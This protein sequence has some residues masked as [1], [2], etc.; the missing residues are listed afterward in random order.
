VQRRQ[1]QRRYAAA[2]H[3]GAFGLGDGLGDARGEASSTY[4]AT[5]KRPVVNEYH[6]VK[7]TDDYQWLENGAD[8]EV[9][10]WTLEQNK[11]TR[12]YFDQAP[13]RAALKEKIKGILSSTS[14]DRYA[15]KMVKDK[16]FAL[17]DQP[18]KQQPFLVVMG[19]PDKAKTEAD[20]KE[21]VLVDPNAIDAKGAT[22]IDWYV[23]S[24]DGKLVAVSMS[25]GGTENG[26]VHVYDVEK[27]AELGDVVPHA[28]SGTAGGSL[29][30][31]GDGKGFYYTRHP[32]AGEVK[33]EDMGFFQQVYFHK[34]GTKDSEDKPLSARTISRGSPRWSCRRART[35]SGSSPACRRATAV[36]T[37]TSSSTRSRASGRASP[38]SRTRSSTRT[39]AP[40]NKLYLLSLKDAPKGK[41]LRVDPAKP[42][43]AKADTLVPHSDVTI[44]GFVVAKSKLYVKDLVGGPSQVRVFDLKGKAAG[45]CPS[46]PSPACGRSCRWTATTCC[47]ATRATRR[48]RPGT[49]TSPK[50]KTPV[51]KTVMAT[52]SSVSFADAEAVR[53]TCTSKDGTKVPDQH[54]PQEGHPA[55]RHEPDVAHRVRRIRHQPPAGRQPGAPRL[56][57]HGRRL[58][59][60]EPARRRRVR[61]GVAPRRQPRQEAERL[62][63]LPRVREVRSWSRS[64]RTRRSS[65]S[66]AARTA[67]C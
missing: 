4:P 5:A 43:L 11:K 48:L 46:R 63:R 19:S 57:R 41:I 50:D 55:R 67:A 13:S 26:T 51:A 32:H 66:W 6:G 15:L 31:A 23:P 62:R 30:W 21:R 56:A 18:P 16:L 61:R 64:T 36:N 8:P 3:R 17:K 24:P 34:L 27:G 42:D 49:P 59:R 1:H 29:T 38:I 37:G 60:G 45:T 14:A 35:A 25:V 53:E 10:A 47:S 54:P 12:A 20:L 22:T 7:V 65:R 39:S 44:Q 58:R 33:P 2:A 40:D 9:K 28:N 52:T